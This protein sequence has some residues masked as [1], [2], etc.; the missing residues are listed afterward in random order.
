MRYRRIV[1]HRDSRRNDAR[2][3]GRR[4]RRAGGAAPAVEARTLAAMVRSGGLLA[5]P[6][7]T[8]MTAGR[9]LGMLVP[10]GAVR[11]HV[12]YRTRMQDRQLG[13]LRGKPCRGGEYEN[14]GGR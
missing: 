5:V 2:R 13:R 4:Q 11:G 10:A 12:V 6:G 1:A 8:L 9:R 3:E 14:A 7:V